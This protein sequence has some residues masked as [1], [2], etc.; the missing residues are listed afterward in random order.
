MADKTTMCHAAS[1][2]VRFLYKL[3]PPPLTSTSLARVPGQKLGVFWAETREGVISLG[4]R[5][6]F[7]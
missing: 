4:F 1:P 7:G 2:C 3:D 6:V 5:L